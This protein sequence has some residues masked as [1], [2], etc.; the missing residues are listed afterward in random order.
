MLEVLHHA[1]ANGTGES[2]LGPDRWEKVDTCKCAANILNGIEG[3]RGTI[4][5]TER[6]EPPP[7]VINETDAET[8]RTN[9]VRQTYAANIILTREREGSHVGFVRAEGTRESRSDYLRDTTG[10]NKD[11][12]FVLKKH[13]SMK[14]RGEYADEEVVYVS[15]R[16]DG[17]YTITYPTPPAEGTEWIENTSELTGGCVE[18]LPR[19]HTWDRPRMSHGGVGGSE[20]GHL[21]GKVDPADPSR[22][23]ETVERS[24]PRVQDG[25]SG[26]L[27]ARISWDLTRCVATAGR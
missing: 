22:L 17:T 5:H 24:L 8:T 23:K 11:C 19:Q 18:W 15:V 7:Q 9:S 25:I 6:F 10:K 2:A 27:Q 3:W 14:L 16:H 13:Y 12:P 21:G 20:L 4:T 26:V 1:D